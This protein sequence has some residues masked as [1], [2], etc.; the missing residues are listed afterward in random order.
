MSIRS[1]K[2]VVQSRPTLE[3]AGVQGL[4]VDVRRQVVLAQRA[5]GEL[6]DDGQGVGVLRHPR[7]VDQPDDLD[8]LLEPDVLRHV[9]EGAARPEGALP[10]TLPGFK[11]DIY[12]SGLD[13]PRKMLAAPNGDIF[14][15]ETS[16]GEITVF[17]GLKDG[18]P[19]QK[20]TFASGLKE[21]FG[22]AFYPPGK[23]PQWVYI[24][25]T[26]SVKRFAYHNGDLKATGQPQ[27]IVAEIFPGAALP[28]LF[29]TVNPDGHKRPALPPAPSS[30]VPQM[31]F[32]Q[33]SWFGAPEC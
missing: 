11:V 33:K 6:A 9:Q 7:L 5:L 1:V 17:R 14:L 15:A 18:K 27:T 16:K 13:E 4:P 3:G 32:L 8:R 10:K 25:D 23:D 21:P 24:G 22:I 31:C 2:R 28:P 19:E 30:T 29:R 12:A 20:S 26:D